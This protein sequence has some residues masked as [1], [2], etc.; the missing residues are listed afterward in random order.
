MERKENS[1]QTKDTESC[2]NKTV[3]GRRGIFY[4]TLDFVPSTLGKDVRKV[5]N[6]RFDALIPNF[7]LKT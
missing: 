7:L 6:V 5:S 4:V 3:F 2:T 1:I